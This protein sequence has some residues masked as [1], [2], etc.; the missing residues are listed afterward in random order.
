MADFTVGLLAWAVPA[1]VVFG[2][3]AI[4]IIAIGWA[5]RA[6]RRS[7]RARAA[8]GQQRARAGATLVQ[9]DD[10]VDELDLEVGLSGALYG[11]GAPA[12]LRRAR[13]TAQH[14]RDESFEEYRLISAPDAVPAEIR[15]VSARIQQRSSEALTTITA[16]RAEHARWVQTNVSAAAQLAAARQRLDALAASMGDP[17]ALVAELSARFA[18]DEWMGASRAARAAEDH[19]EEAERSLALAART[20]DDP[21]RSALADLA[22]AER[23]LRRAEAEAR[24]MEETH[25]LVMQAAQAVPGEL[26]AARTALRQAFVTREQLD[27]ADAARLGAELRSIDGEL[28]GLEADAARRPTRTIDRIARLRDRLDLALGDARTAQQRIRG[29]RTALPGTLAAA[30]NAVAHAESSVSHTRASAD[31]RSRLVSAQRE[32]A[33]AR[34]AQDPVEALDAARRAMRDAEDAQALADFDRLGGR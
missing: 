33:S 16:A 30:R 14:V 15:R 21:S 19:A 32:L 22:T 10:A 5:V 4:A 29:A 24:T 11:G 6:A 2:V 7:P 26:A 20:V 17:A 12:S 13:L 9:L 8:A 28:T 34:Q 27:P 23:A 25:R 3:T 31:A 18:E 1:L